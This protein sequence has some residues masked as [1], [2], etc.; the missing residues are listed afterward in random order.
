LRKIGGSGVAELETDRLL[1]RRWRGGD[2]DAY[3]RMCA[4]PEVMRYLSGRMTRE[5]CEAQIARFER[6][7]T[8]RGF[9]LWAVEDKATGMFIGFV[10]LLYH[11]DWPEGDDKTEVGWRLDRSFWGR[12]LATE[13]ALASVRYGFEKLGLERIISITVPENIASRRVMEK[14][15]L[16]YRGETHWRGYDVVWYV[17]D[18]R[19]WEAG[20]EAERLT[21]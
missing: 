20:Q 19:D 11:D 9:G 1:L 18:R 5:Q 7:W 8:E 15:G 14:A 13:G 17:I 6:G 2:L 3:A 16:T 12:G 10:G 4:D 21:S